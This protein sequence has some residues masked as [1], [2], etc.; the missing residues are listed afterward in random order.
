MKTDNV[1]YAYSCKSCTGV[2][3]K[4]QILD[5][6]SGK[7]KGKLCPCGGSQI[8]PRNLTGWDWFLPRVWKLALWQYLGRLAPSPEPT[9][10]E[11]SA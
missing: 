7:S 9:R 3:T 8:T 11:P 10:P 5:L 2:V 4:L 6:M 1:F